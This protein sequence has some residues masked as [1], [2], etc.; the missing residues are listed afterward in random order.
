MRYALETTAA[1]PA[2]MTRRFSHCS[3]STQQAVLRLLQQPVFAQGAF[4][5]VPAAEWRR[6]LH[7]TDPLIGATRDQPVPQ[8]WVAEGAEVLRLL[9]GHYLDIH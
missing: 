5:P 4:S 7:L 9:A 3:L 2:P 6:L 8:Y 1:A